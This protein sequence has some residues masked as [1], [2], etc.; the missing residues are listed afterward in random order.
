MS[1]H[2]KEK[3]YA[4]PDKF[5]GKWLVVRNVDLPPDT[6]SE[7]GDIIQYPGIACE[8]E[9]VQWSEENAT[10]RAEAVNQHELKVGEN[11]WIFTGYMKPI[12]VRLS[13]FN[14]N[15]TTALFGELPRRVTSVYNTQKEA[16][17][18]GIY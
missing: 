12:C 4:V 18:I 6:N 16:E 9:S 17:T 2:T 8:E 13:G 7:T 10:K 15:M 14:H 11:Y 1:E 5:S 3:W